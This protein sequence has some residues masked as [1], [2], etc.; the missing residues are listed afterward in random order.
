MGGRGASSSGGASAKNGM[1]LFNG[2]KVEFNG[3]LQFGKK[4][5][6]LSP[7]VRAVTEKWENKRVKNKI[8]YGYSVD[9][10]G[11]P[12]GNEVKGSKGRVFVPRI[13]HD[14]QDATFT[15]IHPRADGSGYLG[16]T[17]SKAD[18]MN[19]ANHKNKIVRAAAAEGT[20]SMSKGSNF[21][22]YGFK[23][24]VQSVDAKFKR[25]YKQ[26]MDALDKQ[27]TSG[28]ISWSDYNRQAAIAFNNGVIQVHNDY[29]AGQKQYG[30]I[31]TLEKR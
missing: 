12:V 3:T 14:T 10:N 18:L 15:H 1:T 23:N 2:G 5:P 8:E 27:V 28:A 11:N 21:N 24:Y 20:Y 13:F 29:L 25:D 31:Y 30:Y 16:G 4:D 17:F 6:T 9:A 26:K 22:A 7:T 19:L